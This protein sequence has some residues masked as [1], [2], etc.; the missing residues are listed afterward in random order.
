MEAIDPK[1]EVNGETDSCQLM[2]REIA[3]L[4]AQIAARQRQCEALESETQYFQQYAASMMNAG[5]LSQPKR[6]S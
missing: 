2:Q 1:T 5:V 3:Y 4:A 6:R